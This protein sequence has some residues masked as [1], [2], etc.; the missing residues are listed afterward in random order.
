VTD[1]EQ[2]LKD[3][4]ARIREAR[5]AAKM[6]QD[7]LA[8]KSGIPRTSLSTIETA[9]QADVGI[10]VL[11]GLAEALGTTLAHLVYGDDTTAQPAE[12]VATAETPPQVEVILAIPNHSITLKGSGSNRDVIADA[13]WALGEATAM[14]R[15][16]EARIGQHL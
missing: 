4:G 9:K 1:H 11:L 16:T 7:V 8:G 15:G 2:I 3:I 14:V 5:K 6:S 10:T 12:H 13:V